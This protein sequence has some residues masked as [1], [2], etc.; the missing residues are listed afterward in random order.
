[1]KNTNGKKITYLICGAIV[2]F[3][4]GFFGG[5]GG[6]VC[7]PVLKKFCGYTEKQA[8]ATSIGVIL[9]L[10]IVSSF[11]YIFN[12]DMEFLSL[13]LLTIGAVLG[14]IM[15]AKILNKLN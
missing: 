4:N 1:M 8:H 7:V 14:G 9:P 12:N 11:V 6:M 10:S 15:G 5:G 13:L 3:V 2:G